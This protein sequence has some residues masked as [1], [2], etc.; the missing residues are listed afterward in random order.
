MDRSQKML[1]RRRILKT[2]LAAFLFLASAGKVKAS[3]ATVTIEN[4]GTQAWT[5]SN[6]SQGVIETGTENPDI[7]VE[8]GRRYEF[9]NDGWS[10]HPFQ[11]LD[12]NGAVLLSQDGDGAFEDDGGVQWTD[13]GDRFGFTVTAELASHL[14]VYHC[15]RHSAMYGDIMTMED[16]EN[17]AEEDED[18]DIQEEDEADDQ[19]PEIH[20]LEE[21][22]E[23]EDGDDEENPYQDETDQRQENY[24]R[25]E[26]PGQERDGNNRTTDDGE[27]A[28]DGTTE[29]EDIADE[30][31]SDQIEAGSDDPEDGPQ[32]LPGFGFVAAAASIA[33]GY[34]IKRQMRETP[35]DEGS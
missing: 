12:E 34:L 22:E 25:D 30:T 31:D 7:V 26:Q 23:T 28:E 8:Q 9:V 10:D 11:I 6:D 4:V 5:V 13:D 18:T 33:S 29:D 16:A 15:T 2:G 24:T 35:S 3:D 21:P 19:E 1:P 17:R 20:E 14:H 27:L 32:E